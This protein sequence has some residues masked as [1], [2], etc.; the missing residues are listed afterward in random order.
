MKTSLNLN[1]EERASPHIIIS[2]SHYTEKNKRLFH[3]IKNV[4]KFSTLE[5]SSEKTARKGE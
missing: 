2:S 5:R 3:V 1:G 4:R